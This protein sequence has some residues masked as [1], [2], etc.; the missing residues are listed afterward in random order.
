MTQ[1][2]VIPVTS[3]ITAAGCND[4]VTGIQKIEGMPLVRLGALI[5]TEF[6]ERAGTRVKQD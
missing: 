6:E 3:V 5:M 4:W 2:S 1:H